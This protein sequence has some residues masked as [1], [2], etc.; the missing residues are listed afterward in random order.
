M[1]EINRDKYLKKKNENHSNALHTLM[2]TRVHGHSLRYLNPK[3]IFSNSRKFLNK[4]LF[5]SN[6][7][8]KKKK[9]QS[10]ALHTR[11]HI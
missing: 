11:V 1:G 8:K 3:P 5:E 10:N 7:S 6:K 9:N 2:H 4:H